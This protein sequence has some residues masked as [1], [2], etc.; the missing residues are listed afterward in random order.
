LNCMNYSSLSLKKFGFQVVFSIMRSMT[1]S[2]AGSKNKTARNA[3]SAPR[4]SKRPIEDTI[5]SD[6][7]AD[8]MNPTLERIDADTPIENVVSS[9][10]IMADFQALVSIRSFV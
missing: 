3:S 1:T 6:E 4:P 9:I 5:G 2:S 10:V 8:K 7:V